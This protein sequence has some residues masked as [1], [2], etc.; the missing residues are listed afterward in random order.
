MGRYL[1]SSVDMS[2]ITYKAKSVKKTNKKNN[3]FEMS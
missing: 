3:N 1:A 2:T